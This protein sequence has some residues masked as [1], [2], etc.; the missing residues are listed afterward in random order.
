[1]SR[2]LIQMKYDELLK[3]DFLD[4]NFSITTLFSIM[5]FW[6]GMKNIQN[7]SHLSS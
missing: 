2:F 6:K 5:K 4:L 3:P 7:N 1:M